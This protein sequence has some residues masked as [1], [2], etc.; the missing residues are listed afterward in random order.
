M[1]NFPT[2]LAKNCKIYR[3]GEK[4]EIMDLC[5]GLCDHIC[6]NGKRAMKKID[7]KLSILN[8][9]ASKSIQKANKL[10]KQVTLRSAS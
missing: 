1:N 3:D 10:I 9:Q 6:E 2:P 8:G 7:R 4:I 5:G